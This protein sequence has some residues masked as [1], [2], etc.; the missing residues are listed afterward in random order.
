MRLSTFFDGIRGSVYGRME[1]GNKGEYI[2][3]LGFQRSY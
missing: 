3:G 1:E 2:Y